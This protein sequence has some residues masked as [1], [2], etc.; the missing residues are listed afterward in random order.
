MTTQL[1]HFETALLA[2][3]RSV[4]E[5]RR[6]RRRRR[7]LYAGMAAAAAA[8][9]TVLVVPGIGNQP[10]YAVTTDVDGEV[11][12]RV[13]SLEDA[14]GLE[15]ALAAEG[16]AADV[17]YLADG[18]T[19]ADGRYEQAPDTAGDFSFSTGRDYGYSV[20][21]DAGVVRPGETLVIAASQLGDTGA[22]VS[23][24]VATGAVAPCDPVAAPA[25][26]PES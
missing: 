20:D 4:V 14:D 18:M 17:T 12:V 3:L 11:H 19:C 10:A 2:E 1:D 13:H 24:G 5:E 22:I 15:Q 7:Y 16:V 26:P 25:P 23:I 6:P 9:V 8:G 21:M